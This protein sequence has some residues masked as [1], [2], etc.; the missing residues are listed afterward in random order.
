[1]NQGNAAELAVD[2]GEFQDG[3]VRVDFQDQQEWT[4]I[5]HAIR[6]R[7]SCFELVIP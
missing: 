5:R 7:R 4:A 6:H 1:M 2:D 3:G